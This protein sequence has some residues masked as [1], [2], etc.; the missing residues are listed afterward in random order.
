[1]PNDFFQ[2][3]DATG[4]TKGSI[5]Q[6]ILIVLLLLTAV[7]GYLYFFTGLI[8]PREQITAVP[9]SRVAPIKQPLPPRLDQGA[10]EQP[11]AATPEDRQPAPATAEKTATPPAS[12]EAKPAVAPALKP[13]VAPAPKPAVAPAPKP[14]V[15][16]APKPAVAPAPKPAQAPVQAKS[17][18]GIKAEEKP[19]AKMQA[20]APAAP[21]LPSAKAQK[22]IKTKPAAVAAGK[23]G[24]KVK[25]AVAGKETATEGRYLLLA[26]EFASERETEKSRLKLEKQGLSDV[27]VRKIKKDATM[28]RLFL[29]DFDS[30]EA[31]AAELSK[32]QPQTG[33]AFILNEKG[34]YALYA[35]S[36]LQE[37]GAAAEQKRLAGKGVKLTLKTVMV[38]LPISEVTAG[39]YPAGEDARKEANRLKKK[40]IVVR[41][42]KSGQ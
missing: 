13:A 34:R 26:G 2:D 39:S 8:K 24:K 4:G 36:Y 5:R 9:P 23:V 3:V 33:S 29:A 14:A 18:K 41:V 42:I 16:P 6:G 27:R 20:K 35:G 32:L 19:A 21:A 7:L 22:D 1:M 38:S 31:A 12:P 40:G 11:T 25:P 10:M 37:K 28:H 30:Y 17:A 15:A